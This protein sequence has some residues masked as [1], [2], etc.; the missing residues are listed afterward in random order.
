MSLDGSPG[1]PF[2]VVGFLDLPWGR[3][4][5]EEIR[6]GERISGLV[7]AV[8]PDPERVLLSMAA[9]ADPGL[10]GFLDGL[11]RG[12]VL[13]GTVASIESFGVFVALDDG[14]AHPVFPGVGFITFPEL[15]WRYF[16]DA[17]D[18]VRVGQRVSCEFLSNGEARLSLRATL[19]DPFRAFAEGTEIG[20]VLPGRVTKVV[21]FGFF[22]LVADGVQGL[23]PQADAGADVEAG[24]EIT[25]VVTG[26]EREGRRV[27]FARA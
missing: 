11:R 26:I 3:R 24:D 5:R 15:S 19:P 22:V 12:E 2:G 14:P 9:T 16:E 23:V 7:L 20:T 21:P 18:V 25:V 8:E 13:A 1:G 6:A 27:T 17:S 4:G 10:W